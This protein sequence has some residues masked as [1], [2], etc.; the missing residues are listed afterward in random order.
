L[1][2]PCPYGYRIPTMTE[3]N[4]E[5]GSWSSANQAG[6]YDSPLKLPADG[7]RHG[8]NGSV[9][10]GGYGNY[11]SSDFV[12][13]NDNAYYLDINANSGIGS[14]QRSWGMAIRCIKN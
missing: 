13:G 1:S 9:N 6:A 3:L 8:A 5:F 2:N 11:W 14:W 4:N 10:A 7:D 12:S